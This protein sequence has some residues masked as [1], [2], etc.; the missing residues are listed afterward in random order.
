[1][2]FEK[3]FSVKSYCLIIEISLY[4]PV[5]LNCFST[6]PY[7]LTLS[8]GCFRNVAYIVPVGLFLLVTQFSSDEKVILFCIWHLKIGGGGTS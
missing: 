3:R 2:E 5:F 6:G 8:S 1:M 7:S 4:Y